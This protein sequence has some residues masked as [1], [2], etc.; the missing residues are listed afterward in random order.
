[1]PSL[2]EKMIRDGHLGGYIP[3]GDPGTWC[4]ALWTWAMETFKIQSMLD[5]GCGE[6]HSARF[7]HERGCEVQGVEGCEEA[8]RNSAIPGRV[9]WH[10]YTAGPYRP[11]KRYDLVWSCEFLEHVEAR[12]LDN[13][14]A[15]LAEADKAILITHGLPH[16]TRGHHHVNLQPNSYWISHIESLGFRCDVSLTLAARRATLADYPSINH[17]ARSGLVFVRSEAQ[18]V[19]P[20]IPI[21]AQ[22]KEWLIASRFR[23]SKDYLSKK[24]TRRLKRAG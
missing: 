4:P 18:D 16:Q 10:D 6:G 13:I 8:L 7:F 9:V 15:T 17:F 22:L 1:M 11:A 24:L 19:R 23:L 2:D 5:M 3:G 12:Y 21:S 20:L 14:K